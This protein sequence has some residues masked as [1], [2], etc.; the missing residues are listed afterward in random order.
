[1]SVVKTLTYLIRPFSLLTLLLL[2]AV[3][4][5][6]SRARRF[7]WLATLLALLIALFLGTN[8]LTARLGL[9]LEQAYPPREIAALPQA[10][11]I[12][13]LGGGVGG[14][15]PG[16]P[17]PELF[18]AADRVWHAARLYHAGKAPFVMPSGTGERS[19][20]Y[21]FLR[22]LG[23]PPEAIIL[24]T[25]AVNTLDH[26]F[27]IKPILES[28]GFESVLL[29]TSAYHMRRAHM[30]FQR[31]NIACEPVATDHEM[32]Y[33]VKRAGQG[34]FTLEPYLPSAMNLERA[35][36]YV[37]EIVGYLGD[38]WRLRSRLADGKVNGP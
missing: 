37:K 31:M 1:M 20:S 2:L 18:G 22:D 15:Y 25:N 21:L 12:V 8:V 14:A 13:V 17:N 35:A 34:A 26:T 38:Q 16:Y 4:L 19:A 10:D 9:F 29:V 30:L 7:S 23:V 28:H 27:Q 24:E 36:C 32:L 6:G 11:V 33:G 5:S 3:A